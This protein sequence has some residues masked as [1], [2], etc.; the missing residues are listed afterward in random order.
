MKKYYVYILRCADGSYYTG[1]TNDPERRL[2]EHQE[3]TDVQ[4]YTH[5]RRPVTL[6]WYDAFQSPMAAIEVEKQIKGWNR[7]KKEALI[8]GQ[9]DLLT[10]LATCT[11]SSHFSRR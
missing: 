3:G 4:T 9:F 6:M 7:R 10:E 1:V 11:N 8:A 5:T 2:A